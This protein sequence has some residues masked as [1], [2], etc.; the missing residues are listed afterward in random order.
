MVSV[1]KRQTNGAEQREASEQQL[2]DAVQTLL[3]QGS[4]YT[5]LSVQRITEEAGMTRSTFYRHFADKTQL[6]I[7]L[8]DPV[9]QTIAAEFWPWW[10]AGHHDGMAGICE[11]VRR[12][13]VHYRAH[14]NLLRAVVETARYDS[15]LGN[16]HGSRLAAM[17]SSLA[18]RMRE[19]QASGHLHPGVNIDETAHILN[20]MFQASILEHLANADDAS[21]DVD[22]VEAMGRALW[23]TMYGDAKHPPAKIERR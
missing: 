12:M 14:F 23:L 13:L 2:M 4:S 5:E 1:T 19:E 11:A 20:W 21:D 15:T 8:T 18:A 9:Y 7:R 6:L 10:D 22:F 16:A 17:T 3:A